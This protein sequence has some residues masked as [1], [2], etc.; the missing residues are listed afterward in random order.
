MLNILDCRETDSNTKKGLVDPVLN[1]VGLSEFL[2]YTKKNPS[3][4]RVLTG[5]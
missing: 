3:F 1:I 4:W 2:G 5:R